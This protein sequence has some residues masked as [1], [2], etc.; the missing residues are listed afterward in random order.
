MALVRGLQAAVDLFRS[1]E[2]DGTALAAASRAV[3][4]AEPGLATDYAACLDPAT[5]APAVRASDA[6]VVAVAARLGATRLID[7]VV[8]GE[9]LEGDVRLAG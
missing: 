7:N 3:L 4:D 2:R 9:G 8:L 6:C 1:G 5:F